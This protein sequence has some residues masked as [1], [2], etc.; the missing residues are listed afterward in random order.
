[1][2]DWANRL[3]EGTNKIL[4]TPR[5]RRKEQCPHKR[6]TQTC[7]VQETPAEAWVGVVCS[8]VRGTECSSACMGHFEGG[9]HY[10][11]YLHHSLASGQT[12]GRE[13]SP[14]NCIKDLLS[15]DPPIRTGP[16]FPPSISLSQQE[17]SISLLSFSIRGQTE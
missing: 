13:H 17:A 7:L 3:L 6:L 16:S 9:H 1:M 11:H 4:R 10:P 8:R 2:Q 14:E 12:T 15:M 5:S